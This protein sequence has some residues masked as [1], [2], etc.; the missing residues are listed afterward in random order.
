MPAPSGVGFEVIFA[1]SLIGLLAAAYVVGRLRR[2]APAEEDRLVVEEARLAA[3][4]RARARARF[5]RILTGAVQPRRPAPATGLRDLRAIAGRSVRDLAGGAAESAK[6]LGTGAAEGTRRIGAGA[7]EG[8]RWAGA[9][10]AEGARRAGA[11][12]IGGVRDVAVSVGRRVSE[13]RAAAASRLEARSRERVRLRERRERELRVR[14]RAERERGERERSA[15]ERSRRGIDRA[16][17]ERPLA[18]SSG[19]PIAFRREGESIASRVRQVFRR[20][21][22]GDVEWHRLEEALILADTGIGP[23]R[24]IV[25]RVR[26][27]FDRRSDPVDLLVRQIAGLF[28]EDPPLRLPK[29]FAV[30]LVVGVNGTG[31][32]STIG[33]LAHSLAHRGRRVAL[34]ASDTFRAAAIPQLAY[35]AD[36]AGAE[37]V[38]QERGADPAAVAFDAARA[39]RTRGQDVLIVDTAG[40][41][42][43]R[44]PLMDELAKVQ[45][46]L[47][48]SAGKVDE[49]LLVLDATTGQNGI[50]QADVF[51]EAVDVTGI[52]LTK[53]DGT[54]K[55]G[56]VLAIR[57]AFDLP[58]KLVGTGEGVDDLR[59]F[60]AMEFA[61]TLVGR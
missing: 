5:R 8:A 6:R 49:V 45:R 13:T 47:V 32:T 36:V 59:S 9:G 60:D 23:A 3:R 7:A 10:A 46:A 44:Q 21:V 20:G 15:R 19:R 12:A 41:I 29:E 48:K 42:H 50:A 40:R 22:P 53:L 57:E 34:A 26:R 58:V 61:R 56:V 4:R 27:S 38:A 51:V 37:L 14:Q 25:D 52:A 33:K 55:G 17:P 11:G 39:A 1:V 18:T 31:K 2:L 35:W 28:A 24:R 16:R 54:A 43:T 30:I